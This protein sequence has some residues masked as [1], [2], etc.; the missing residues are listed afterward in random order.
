M[1]EKKNVHAEKKDEYCEICN[2]KA[3]CDELPADCR[4][5]KEI[6]QLAEFEIAKTKL[7]EEIEKPFIKFLD[8]FEKELQRIKKR[9]WK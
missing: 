7:A 2:I 5:H 9:W 6:K 4:L 3:Y 1:A 8:W